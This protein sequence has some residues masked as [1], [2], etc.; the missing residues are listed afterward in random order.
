MH[1]IESAIDRPSFQ[2]QAVAWLR[3]GGSAVTVRQFRRDE[4]IY[5][6]GHPSS[7]VSCLDTGSAKIVI[8]LPDGR[9]CPL[10]LRVPGELIGELG[11][12]GEEFRNDSV[13]ALERVTLRTASVRAFLGF[14]SDNHLE[15]EMRLHLSERLIAQQ[16]STAILLLEPS[17]RRLALALLELSARAGT[18][19]GAIPLRLSQQQLGDMIGTTRSRVGQFLKKF[20]AR[21][22]VTMHH[23]RGVRIDRERLMAFCA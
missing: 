16:R 11:A 19:D 13:I 17:E 7:T 1:V 15:S 4:S 21:G 18:E 20:R 8:N 12:C 3:R 10:G 2:R 5:L 14:I 6:E 9:E 22:L 23:A